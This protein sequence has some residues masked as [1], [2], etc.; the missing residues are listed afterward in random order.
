[1]LKSLFIYD[2]NNTTTSTATGTGSVSNPGSLCCGGSAG[3]FSANAANVAKVNAFTGRTTAD[4]QVYIDQI[5]NQNVIT[6]NQ[7][8]TK[9]NYVNYVGNGSSND[10]TIT[11]SGNS[12]T[13]VNYVDLQVIGS[14]N[15]VNITQQSTGGSKGVFATVQNNKQQFDHTAKGFRQSLC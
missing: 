14:Q 12:S 8:G 2:A 7:S 13:V 6:V 1:L 15:Y 11:Q 10:I 3:A 9:N 5:G 4:S